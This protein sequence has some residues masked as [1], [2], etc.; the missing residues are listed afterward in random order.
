LTQFSSDLGAGLGEIDCEYP[1][2]PQ[3]A[4]VTGA[5]LTYLAY[6]TPS[7]ARS[8][9]QGARQFELGHGAKPCG[10]Q[11][12]AQMSGTYSRGRAACV[13]LSVPNG[14]IELLWNDDGTGVLGNS[15]F[16][17]PT[18]LSDAIATWATALK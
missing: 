3:A 8:A 2:S 9:L 16:D 1:G 11:A 12:A 10:A 5:S 15:T 7:E 13:V 6:K 17:P 18:R 14:T 4:R